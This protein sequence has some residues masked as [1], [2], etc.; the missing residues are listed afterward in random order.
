MSVLASC[1]ACI[2]WLPGAQ[3]QCIAYNKDWREAHGSCTNHRIQR[4]AKWIQQAHSDRNTNGVIEESPEQILFDVGHGG[5][6]ELNWGSNISWIRLHQDNV[7]GLN[8]NIGACTNCNTHVCSRKCWGVVDTVANHD[9]VFSSVLE[10]PDIRL[11]LAWQDIRDYLVNAELFTNN[12]C[13]CCLIT[14]KH[15]G[16]NTHSTKTSNGG[17][18]GLLNL[19]GHSNDTKKLILKCKVQRC[20]CLSS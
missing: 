5:S 13:C 3:A 19:I 11:F 4:N 10:L 20:F 1:W 2:L 16:L 17:C 6:R 9:N 7:S 12:V 8:S 18:T 15:D 14:G